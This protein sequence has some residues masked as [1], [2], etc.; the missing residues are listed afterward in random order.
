[1]FAEA[2]VPPRPAQVFHVGCKDVGEGGGRR[3]GFMKRV[4]FECIRSKFVLREFKVQLL[5]LLK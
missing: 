3:G 2:K 1:M 5:I 4:C